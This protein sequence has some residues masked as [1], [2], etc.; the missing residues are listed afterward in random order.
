MH[1]ISRPPSEIFFFLYP[2]AARFWHCIQT[3]ENLHDKSCCMEK[4]KERKKKKKYHQF[5][6]CW[7]FP[8]S[9]KGYFLT[10][11][12][13]VHML[14]RYPDKTPPGHNTPCSFWH[15]WT[16]PPS[17]F[18]QGGHNT[19]CNLWKGGQNPPRKFCKVD[20]IPPIMWK[21][22]PSDRILCVYYC[23]RILVP[24]VII[25]LQWYSRQNPFQEMNINVCLST[26]FLFQ[27]CMRAW[28]MKK[29]MGLLS[30][31]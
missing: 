24:W 26:I 14:K 17:S 27:K 18:L 13:T 8:G 16:K 2:Q 3:W 12:S 31:K 19:P 4:K 29:L 30:I 6:I 9:N 10:C 20:K 5:V 21:K 23:Y 1:I 22:P 7:I 15:R 25:C 28:S 11:R